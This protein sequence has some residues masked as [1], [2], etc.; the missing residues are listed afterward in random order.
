MAARIL[1]QGSSRLPDTPSTGQ[2]LSPAQNNT[3]NTHH[4]YPSSRP[5]V[6]ALAMPA[7][8]RATPAGTPEESERASVSARSRVCRR[9][10]GIL[11]GGELGA[12]ARRSAGA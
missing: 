1:E 11:E 10:P 2:V 4:K 5:K 9:R 3:S 8:Q 6:R 12:V 7:C